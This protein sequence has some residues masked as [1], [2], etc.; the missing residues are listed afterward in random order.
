MV[1]QLFR[2]AMGRLDVKTEGPARLEIH[3]RLEASGFRFK[4]LIV[5]LAVNDSY[6]FVA[7]PEVSQ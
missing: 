7:P 5:A 3:E 6:R 2:H 4:E 1:K